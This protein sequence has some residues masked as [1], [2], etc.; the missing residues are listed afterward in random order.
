[1][2][3]GSEP[4]PWHC[5]PLV[6]ASTYGLEL[7]FQY[8]TECHIINDD[9][10]VRLEWDYSKEPGGIASPLEMSLFRTKPTRFYSFITSIDLQ[11]PPGYVLPTQPH[12]SLLL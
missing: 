3:N 10:D 8:E 1:M 5:L 4:E 2:V 11:T 12:P 9:G 6:E 7:I